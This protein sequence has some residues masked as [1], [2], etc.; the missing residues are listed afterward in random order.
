LKQIIEKEKERRKALEGE[1]Q[2]TEEPLVN[3]NIK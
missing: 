3:I 2:I 1:K